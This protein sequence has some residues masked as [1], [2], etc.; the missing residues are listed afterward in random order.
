MMDNHY[1]VIFDKQMHKSCEKWEWLHFCSH[2]KFTRNLQNEMES[3]LQP[4]DLTNRE[5]ALV[6]FAIRCA[7]ETMGERSHD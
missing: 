3:D 2:N 7:L 1:S 6:A 5:R 4:F